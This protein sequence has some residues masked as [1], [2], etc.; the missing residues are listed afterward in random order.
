M[1]NN[2]LLVG[3]VTVTSALSLSLLTLKLESHKHV[4]GV[5]Q[6][7]QAGEASKLD[8]GG[9]SAHEDLCVRTGCRQLALYHVSTHKPHTQV[10][11][12]KQTV[13][14]K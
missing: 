2:T 3:V 5:A 10:K 8:H 6:L 9:R 1:N 4:L 12:G 14:V 7:G 13:Q 11:N